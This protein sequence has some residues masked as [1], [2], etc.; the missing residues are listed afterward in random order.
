MGAEQQGVG[1]E[2]GSLRVIRGKPW[3]Q[4]WP[5]GQGTLWWRLWGRTHM[6]WVRMVWMVCSP[7]EKV[8]VSRGAALHQEER[9]SKARQCPQ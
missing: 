9:G 7:K 1:K 6:V 3:G 2:N 5:Q 4:E 8:L